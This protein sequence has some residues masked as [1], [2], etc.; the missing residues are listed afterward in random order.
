MAPIALKALAAAVALGAFAAMWFAFSRQ[1]PPPPGEAVATRRALALAD[2]VQGALRR[3]AA[4]GRAGLPPASAPAL[5]VLP[6]DAPEGDEALAALAGSM[7]E[8]L[9][10]HLGRGELPA[11]SACH[12][13]RMARQIGLT[14][15]ETARLLGVRALLAGR[16]ERDGERVRVSARLLEPAHASASAP[17]AAPAGKATPPGWEAAAQGA[18]ELWRH[19]ASHDRQRLAELP[20]QLVRR[21]AEHE[22]GRAGTGAAGVPAPPGE[23]YMLYLQAMQQQRRGGGAEALQRAREL[24]DRALAL[25]PEHPPMLLASVALNSQLVAHGV[26]SGARVDA[27]VR[28]TAETLRRVDPEG[29]QTA[30]VAAAAAVGRREWLPAHQALEAATARHPR[31]APLLHTR[32]GI[33]LMTGYLARGRESA[34]RS[35]LIE[36]LNASVHERLARTASLLGDD[37]AMREAA[38]LTRELG[39]PLMA[40]PF[41]AWAALRGGD[42]VQAELHWREVLASARLPQDWIGAVLRAHAAPGD[43]G[44]RGAAVAAIDA[45][46]ADVQRRMN[47]AFLAHALAG[48]AERAMRALERTRGDVPTMWMSDLWLPE[49]AALRRHP[50]FVPYLRDAGLLALWEAHGEPERCRRNGAG[51]WQCD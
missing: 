23:A 10:E 5:A 26:G 21:I 34:L 9:A 17:A 42:A 33:L 11:A 32:A 24:L 46:D 38:A 35:A 19:E 4:A 12:S 15:A 48:D 43:A 36:P 8:A 39:R 22:S 49:L 20:V 16:V 37:A 47:H 27:Q 13:V 3:G 25:A 30:S 31:H 7:C 41:E 18:R 1:T 44:A 45:L 51:Q 2:R 14:P 50:R 6:F 29:P 28:E 40:A